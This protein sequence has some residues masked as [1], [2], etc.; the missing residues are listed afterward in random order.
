MQMSTETSRRD[1]TTTLIVGGGP[2]GL[3][4]ALLLAQQGIGSIIVE[5]RLTRLTAPKAHALNP[6]SL[7]ICAALGIPRAE[8]EARATPARESGRVRFLTTLSGVEIGSLPYERQDAAV[9]DL[10]PTPLLNIS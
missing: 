7:E 5:R 9:L 6:R 3:V 4:A 1:A 10:T 8:F 2:V